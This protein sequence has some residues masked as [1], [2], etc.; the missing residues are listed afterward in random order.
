MLRAI[1]AITLPYHATLMSKKYNLIQG[2]S[3]FQ[4]FSPAENIHLHFS[5]TDTT[6]YCKEEVILED[7]CVAFVEARPLDGESRAALDAMASDDY[8]RP[9]SIFAGLPGEHKACHQLD[10]LLSRYKH[11]AV[12]A[13][14][15]RQQ[16]EDLQPESEEFG[17]VA[18]LL[19]FNS[20][21]RSEAMGEIERIVGGFNR[22]SGYKPKSKMILM[23]RN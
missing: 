16:L 21:E 8:I 3:H 14:D 20:D 1:S 9:M 18:A 23:E 4:P 2:A 5:Y 7:N 6:M 19:G 17:D 13:A 22:T 10:D 12:A 15:L 11:L